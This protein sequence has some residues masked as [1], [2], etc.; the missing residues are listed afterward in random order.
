MKQLILASASPRRKELLAS[1]YAEF[2]ARPVDIEE[3][4][5]PQEM[6]NDYVARLAFEKAT[7]GVERFAQNNTNVWV[8][9][10]DTIVVSDRK[11]LEKPQNKADFERM[12]QLLSGA[13]HQVMTA[14]CLRN[15]E[16]VYN[17]C[18]TTEVNFRALTQSDIEAYWQTGEPT[19]KAGGYGI[20]GLA[21]RFVQSITGSYT[22]VVGLP[23]CE[24]EALLKQAGFTTSM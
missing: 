7:A 14:V 4:P 17:V 18:V 15:N 1:L 11:V 9:G 19:D 2:A 21:A 8:L 10:S 20:Q 3:R 12:M 23:L 22:A 6:P 13:T 16:E 5:L 24:T